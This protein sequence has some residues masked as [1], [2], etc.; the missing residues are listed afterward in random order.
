MHEI[1]IRSFTRSSCQIIYLSAKSAAV[2]L[3]GGLDTKYLSIPRPCYKTFY[4]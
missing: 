3:G 4:F 1:L 2:T